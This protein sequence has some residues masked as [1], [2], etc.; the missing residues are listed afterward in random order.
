[1]FVSSTDCL[2]TAFK[3]LL[4]IPDIIQ[5]NFQIQF[6]KFIRDFNQRSVKCFRSVVDGR[7]SKYGSQ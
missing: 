1:M 2:V 4:K 6:H 3:E 7:N 5:F